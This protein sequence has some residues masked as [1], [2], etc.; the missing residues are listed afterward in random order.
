MGAAADRR[1]I[2]RDRV[3][4]PGVE[5]FINRP[6]RAPVQNEEVVGMNKG[7]R[8]ALIAAAVAGLFMAKAAVAADDAGKAEAKKVHCMGANACK[9][10]GACAGAG[11][12]CAG[13]NACKGKGF[14]E[15]TPE[16]CKAKGG[17]VES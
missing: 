6:A 12:D 7:A 5:A 17:K 14:T 8:G 4:A 2:R 1:A 9:G 10:Q 11:H 3:G 15:T 13:K 16:D